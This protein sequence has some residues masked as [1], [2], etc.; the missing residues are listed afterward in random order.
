MKSHSKRLFLLFK[1]FRNLND[2][3]ELSLH[4]DVSLVYTKFTIMDCWNLSCCDK[5]VR[6]LSSF[7]FLCE[8]LSQRV[9]FRGVLISL[10]FHWIQS[11]LNIFDEVNYLHF[12]LISDAEVIASRLPPNILNV[13]NIGFVSEF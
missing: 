2:S 10:M 7:D 12:A 13:G 3:A 11:L 9:D 5:R 1:K 8:I 6:T 4:T